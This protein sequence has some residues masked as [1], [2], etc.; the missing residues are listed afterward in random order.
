MFAAA[1]TD[2]LREAFGDLAT[3]ERRSVVAD[4]VERRLLVLES[5]DAE[6]LEPLRHP[7]ATLNGG[8]S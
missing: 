7:T 1:I 3:V 2:G 4:V 8:T 6:E 5:P